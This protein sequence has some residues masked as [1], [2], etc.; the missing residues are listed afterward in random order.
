[1]IGS[2]V[3]STGRL[4]FFFNFKLHMSCLST[5]RLL[6]MEHMV[7][8]EQLPQNVDKVGMVLV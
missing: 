2:T 1:M 6:V 8:L 4:F 5:H 7:L 3:K